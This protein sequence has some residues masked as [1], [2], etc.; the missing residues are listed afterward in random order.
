MVRDINKKRRKKKQMVKLITLI[1][2]SKQTQNFFISFLSKLKSKKLFLS[3]FEISFE[4]L[5]NA[6]NDL[7]F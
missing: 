7:I 1:N 4:D 2:L 6:F 3:I 5:A